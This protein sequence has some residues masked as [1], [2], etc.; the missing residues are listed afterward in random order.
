VAFQNAGLESDSNFLLEQL[1]KTFIKSTALINAKGIPY[2]SNFGTTFGSNDL[3][4]HTDITSTYHPVP[5]TFL[6]S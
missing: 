3:W 4:D 2:T 5:G 6:L 1:E